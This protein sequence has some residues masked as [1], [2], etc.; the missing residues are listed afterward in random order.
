MIQCTC[1]L[2]E[3]CNEDASQPRALSCLAFGFSCPLLILLG[4]S[5]CEMNGCIIF[6]C[7]SDFKKENI[8]V[9]TLILK[10]D[11]EDEHCFLIQ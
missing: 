8:N 3:H 4:I 2:G 5:N 1:A 9:L 11:L 7:K 6:L 10:I